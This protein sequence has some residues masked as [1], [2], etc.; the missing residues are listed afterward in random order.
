MLAYL[1]YALAMIGIAASV[2]CLGLWIWSMDHKCVTFGSITP[3]FTAGAI[4]I[5]GHG[6]ILSYRGNGDQEW[7][8]HTQEIS[9]ASTV[10][11]RSDRFF[12]TSIGYYFPLW[13]PALIFALAGA[14]SLRLDRRFNL[15]SAIITTTLVAG[16]LGLAVAL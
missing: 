16:L 9:P 4:V 8:F 1:R 13:Y 14:A 6:A 11:E 10:G 15:R 12:T 7:Q 3:S 2:G 5:H